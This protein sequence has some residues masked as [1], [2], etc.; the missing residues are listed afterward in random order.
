MK[1]SYKKLLYPLMLI[2]AAYLSGCAS[3]LPVIHKTIA[4]GPVSGKINIQFPDTDPLTG[5]KV[6]FTSV[7]YNFSKHITDLT[8]YQPAGNTLARSREAITPYKGLKVSKNGNKYDFDYANG[9]YFSGSRRYYKSDV[10][11]T[12]IMDDQR[13]LTLSPNYQIA[14]ATSPIGDEYPLLDSAENLQADAISIISKLSEIEL[15]QN[16]KY[17][18]NGELNVEYSPESIYA[19]FERL[20]GKYKWKSNE[21]IKEFKKENT[22]KL[23]NGK[24][25]Y[26]LHVEIYPYRNGSKV[27]YSAQVDYQLSS[28]GYSTV[29]PEDIKSLK[30]TVHNTAKN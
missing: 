15:M 14:S 11:F 26:P 23:V 19:N 4:E 28:K 1:I 3:K 22:F 17:T 6:E 29:T 8:S 30:E 12:A 25:T 16:K 5:E 20:M 18:F 10:F 13:V 21:T 2:L 24:A 27:V 7:N 9:E